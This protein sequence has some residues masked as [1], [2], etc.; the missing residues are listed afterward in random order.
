MT[1]S[2]AYLAHLDALSVPYNA[3]DNERNTFGE[4]PLSPVIVCNESSG[5]GDDAFSQHHATR[6]SWSRLRCLPHS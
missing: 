5:Q 1:E 4:T 2:S 6:Q 3:P